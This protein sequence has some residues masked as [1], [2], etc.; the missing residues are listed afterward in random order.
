MAAVGLHVA[1][2]TPSFGVT[3]FRLTDLDLRD[4]HVYMNLP[5]I[6]CRDVTDQLAFGFSINNNLQT[7]IQTDGDGDGALDL[8][9][10]V[11]FDPLD[12]AGPGGPIRFG[13]A[14]CT[15]PMGSTVCGPDGALV[16]LTSVN[17]SAGTCLT[18]LP[19]TLYG[20]YIPDVTSSIA[21]CFASD[22]ASLSMDIGIGVPVPLESA[23][24]GATYV[25]SPATNLVNG[26]IMGF[27]S[28][29][30]ADQII[31]PPGGVG[32]DQPLSALFPGGTTNCS[33]HDDRDAGPGGTGWWMYFNFVA[34]QVPYD[35]PT[36]VGDGMIAAPLTNAFPNPFRSSVRFDYEL[37]SPGSVRISV[38]DVA[39]RHVADLAQGM[40][41]AGPHSVTWDG[42]ARDGGHAPAGVYM[43]R[44]SR[45]EGV[46]VRTVA[47]LR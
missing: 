18:P 38:F 4:P 45:G 14:S 40:L 39:G 15:A 46:L 34:T 7:L 16:T 8:S 10:L 29:A 35:D 21:P 17:S 22:P 33:T 24:I 44:L 27:L 1:A 6:G 43:I 41:P 9:Y 36:A 23:R 28:E 42:R 26:L 31:L 3:A 13:E 25:G 11:I 20:P 30:V 32:G 2:A 47:L 37:P 19:G 5:V 12:Q